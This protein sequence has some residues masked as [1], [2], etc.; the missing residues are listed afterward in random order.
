MN[1]M[2][3][4]LFLGAIV[5]AFL[6]TRASLAA[7]RRYRLLCNTLPGPIERITS[8]SLVAVQGRVS[9]LSGSLVSPLRN[10]P[11]VYARLHLQ[12]G[13]RTKRQGMSWMTVVDETVQTN[14]LLE[15]ETGAVE[16][17]L[18][19]AEFILLPDF[20][21]KNTTPADAAAL[22]PVLEAYGLPDGRYAVEETVIEVGDSCYALGEATP[23]PN[24]FPVLV[25]GRSGLLLVSDLPPYDLAQTLHGRLR[26]MVGGSLLSIAAT[27]LLLWMGPA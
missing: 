23:G 21:R 22:S 16:I 8:E 5:S 27:L 6:L 24:G 14:C 15:D 10:T 1:L 11:C 13:R 4:L 25:P 17:S 7:W 9:P 2:W 19:S 12:K 18:D 26:R 3:L 20:H